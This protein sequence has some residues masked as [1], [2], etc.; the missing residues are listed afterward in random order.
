MHSILREKTP[1]RNKTRERNVHYISQGKTLK[2]NKKTAKS[3]H[4]RV[5]RMT[6][7]K[8]YERQGKTHAFHIRAEE[9]KVRQEA[10]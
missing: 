2:Q 10:T 4:S 8:Q 6:P 5:E 7:K 3:M 1:K 9:P